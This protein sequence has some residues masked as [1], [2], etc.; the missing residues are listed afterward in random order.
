MMG[1]M[2]MERKKKYLDP[3]NDIENGYKN[4]SGIFDGDNKSLDDQIG[5]S[6]DEGLRNEVNH[7][8][9]GNLINLQ[10]KKWEIFKKRFNSIFNRE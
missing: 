7:F 5:I 3:E 8:Y 10:M 1:G 4:Y 2:N 6:I 9:I